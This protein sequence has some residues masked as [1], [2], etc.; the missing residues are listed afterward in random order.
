MDYDTPIQEVPIIPRI[1]SILTDNGKSRRYAPG[2]PEVE[3]QIFIKG[4]FFTYP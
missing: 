2:K 4:D 1:C 3:N